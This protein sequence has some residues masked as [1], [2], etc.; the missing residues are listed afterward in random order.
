MPLNEADTRA[1]LIDP[2]LHKCGWTEDLIRRE[3]TAVTVEIINGKALKAFRNVFG[4]DA[5]KVYRK[6]DGTNNAKNAHIHIATDTIRTITSQFESSGTE[7]LENPQI[8]QTPEVRLADGPAA[9]QMACNPRDLL[10]ET[11]A[12]MFAA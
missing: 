11:K 1:K 5:A 12:R 4:A 3:E 10:I 6:P 8:F 2:A 7:G 9:L